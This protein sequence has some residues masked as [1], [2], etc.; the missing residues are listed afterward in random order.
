MLALLL[1]NWPWAFL[2]YFSDFGSFKSV[3]QFYDTAEFEMTSTARNAANF[4]KKKIPMYGENKMYNFPEKSRWVQGCREDQL[5]TP[6]V[7]EGW[8]KARGKKR[9][10]DKRKVLQIFWM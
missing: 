7:E 8:L 5:K 6:P 2:N 1:K 9:I 4:E 3:D 10:K